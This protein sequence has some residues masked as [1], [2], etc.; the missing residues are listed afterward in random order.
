MESTPQSYFY[1]NRKQFKSN[2]DWIEKYLED[3]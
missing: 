1:V 3:T 2:S